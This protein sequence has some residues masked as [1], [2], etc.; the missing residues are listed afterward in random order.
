MDELDQVNWLPADQELIDS[1]EVANASATRTTIEYYDN[2]AAAFVKGTLDVD[3][4][5]VQDKFATL[6]EEGAHILDFGCG[7]GRD[8]EYFSNKGFRVDATDGSAELCK[9]ATE[10]TGIPVRQMLFSQLDAVDEYD[11]IW[12]CS[13]ILHCPKAELTD[14]FHRMIRATKNGG[15]IYA[16]F[17]YGT[18]EGERNGRYFT[19]FTAESYHE[20]LLDYP[21]LSIIE[22]WVSADVRPGRGDEKWLNIILRKQA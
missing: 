14:V 18:F 4:G 22:E 12:A 3:F 19:Y 15:I 16:S 8:T 6:L 5:Y 13:S 20:F 2:N 11:G 21:E 17:K 1:I 7:S 9:I 10:Y